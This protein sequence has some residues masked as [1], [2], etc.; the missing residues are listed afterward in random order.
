MSSNE[1]VLIIGVLG[2]LVPL[3]T[4]IGFVVT[5]R[6]HKMRKMNK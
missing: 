6:E 1:W 3:F 2:V 4:I 5:W